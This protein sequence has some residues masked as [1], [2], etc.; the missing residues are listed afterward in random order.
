MNFVGRALPLTPEDM[1]E[2]ADWLQ[3][4]PKVIDAVCEVEA[5]RGGFLA[6]GR[7]EILFE[8]HVFGRLT[9]NQYDNDHPNISSSSWNRA[10]YGK[11]G[12]H[13]YDRLAEALALDED[14]ALKS[15]SWGK[16][17]VMGENHAVCGYPDVQSFV[18]DMLDSERNHLIAFARFCKAR[19]LDG[20]LRDHDWARF[21]RGYN[22]PGQVDYYADKLA[23][24]YD[25][26]S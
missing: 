10:L 26:A 21:A 8:A 11:G 12:G 23:E 25:A 5:P 1:Q 22:G 16:F 14:A 20:Y 9:D 6:D 17:Q 13:Q 4:E 18:A 3:C 2:V 19:R 15:A 7:P 24:A